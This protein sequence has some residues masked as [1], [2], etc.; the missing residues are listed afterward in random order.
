M[1]LCV[2]FDGEGAGLVKKNAV[3]YKINKK[4]NIE[5]CCQGIGVL[6]YRL[7]DFYWRR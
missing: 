2:D 6:V 7:I 5:D 4:K 3:H 1:G